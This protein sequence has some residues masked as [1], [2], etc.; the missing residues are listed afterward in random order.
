MNKRRQHVFKNLKG[1]SQKGANNFISMTL[2]KLSYSPS[3]HIQRANSSSINAKWER[4]L[5]EQVIAA[6]S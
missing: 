3:T 6:E 5:M 1:D 2:G 4:E